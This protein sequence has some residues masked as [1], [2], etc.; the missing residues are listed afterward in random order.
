MNQHGF[1]QDD[2]WKG[3]INEPI[4]FLNAEVMSSGVEDPH[5]EAKGRRNPPKWQFGSWSGLEAQYHQ[6]IIT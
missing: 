3:F 2:F 4:I 1:E 5:M 6:G